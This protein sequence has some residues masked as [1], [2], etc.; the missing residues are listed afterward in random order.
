MCTCNILHFDFCMEFSRLCVLQY[1]DPATVPGLNPHL[2]FDHSHVFTPR[3]V[4][5]VEQCLT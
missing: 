4:Y 1:I 3:Q 2:G 5:L